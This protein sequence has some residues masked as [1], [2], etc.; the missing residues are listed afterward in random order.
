[1]SRFKLRISRTPRSWYYWK[2]IAAITRGS[3]SIHQLRGVYHQ[4]LHQLNVITYPK[5]HEKMN[6]W[7]KHHRKIG[8]M[9]PNQ[10]GGHQDGS[11]LT[12]TIFKINP[13][14]LGS[15]QPGTQEFLVIISMEHECLDRGWKWNYTFN[16]EVTIFTGPY[17]WRI[18]YWKGLNYSLHDQ[19]TMHGAA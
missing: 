2:E 10:L 19:D 1:M 15:L 9:A 11:Q 7:I 8:Q 3:V 12:A 18:M 13:N 4:S 17:D 16:E 6:G 14:S 5:S